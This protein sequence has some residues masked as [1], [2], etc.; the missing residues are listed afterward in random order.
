[1]AKVIDVKKLRDA[2]KASISECQNALTA[3]NGNYLEA[4][5]IIKN[6]FKQQGKKLEDRETNEGIIA[7][8]MNFDRTCGVMVD[9][10]CETDFVAK[11]PVFIDYCK[12]IASTLE[13]NLEAMLSLQAKMS[14]T[15]PK[16][17][18]QRLDDLRK[19]AD[20]VVNH[21]ISEASQVFGE[22]IQLKNLFEINAAFITAYIHPDNKSA[23][24]I[25]FNNDGGDIDLTE[26]GK[27]LAMQITAM[28]PISCTKEDLP[29][30]LIAQITSDTRIAMEDKPKDLQERIISGKIE[31]FCKDKTLMLQRYIKDESMTVADYIKTI[32]GDRAIVVS[33][34]ITAKKI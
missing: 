9:I 15:A 31:A 16:L 33:G 13:E 17:T 25:G 20:E 4:L 1:M 10:A 22:N 23:T 11:S 29:D 5:E 32:V 30:G 14:S 21:I 2:T 27:N 26:L 24:I 18:Q 28:Q 8:S 34:W 6:K 7:I 3:S 19:T 12:Q